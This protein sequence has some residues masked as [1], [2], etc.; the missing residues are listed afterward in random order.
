[1]ILPKWLF[2]IWL[3]CPLAGGVFAQALTQNECPKIILDQGLALAAPAGTLPA[4]DLAI[5]HE[6]DWVKLN[7]YLTKDHRHV[8]VDDS[9]FART[10]ASSDSVANYTVT[11][12]QNNDAG[13][14]FS[15]RFA[16]TKILTLSEILHR[17][18]SK[19]NILLNCRRVD[20]DILVK[21]ILDAG[22]TQQVLI[23]VAPEIRQKIKRTDR[24]PIVL[25]SDFGEHPSEAYWEKNPP[26]VLQLPFEKVSTEFIQALKQK[27]SKILVDCSGEADQIQSWFEL[28]NL[29]VDWILTKKGDALLATFS[30][31]TAVS[32]KSVLISAHRGVLALAP[33]NT[34]A[35]YRKAIELGLDFIEI[36]VRPTRDTIL[37]SVHDR[38]L[39]RTTGLARE[40]NSLS[41][42]EIRELSAG[43]WFG[44]PFENEKVPTL[45]EIFQL[46]RGKIGFYVDFK[47]GEPCQLV[48]MM[49]RFDVLG[50]CVIYGS[51]EQLLSIRKLAPQAR[52]MPGLK[53]SDQIES[54]IAK[55]HP[56]AFDTSWK[57]L[58]PELIQKCH[59][60]GVKV[61]SDAMG[62]HENIDDFRQA[63]SWG[64]DC[65]QTDEPLILFRALE[66]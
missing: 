42:A 58:S 50:A 17:C 57:I 31:T 48:E 59:R 19:M 63:I 11:E 36:D 43:K 39:K 55:C 12:I 5:H 49:R 22:M 60:A 28:K 45:E 4:I 64:I 9:L 29:A 13:G 16:G 35:A 18:T 27:N 52:I 21:E 62:G 23:S 3:F 20:P 44:K 38:S 34:L 15:P 65:I 2:R 40:V 46:G 56:Y 25:V 32:K 47:D 61:F 1:M 8:V 51:V 14:W 54:L 26:A 33:E 41:L 6:F 10:M 66:K 24:N 53:N 30:K 37:V 7:V